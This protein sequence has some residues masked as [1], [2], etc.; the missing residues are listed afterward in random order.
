[1]CREE[2]EKCEEKKKYRE[3]RNANVKK[4]ECGQ[5]I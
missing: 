3:K 2:E 1:M 4:S 5:C